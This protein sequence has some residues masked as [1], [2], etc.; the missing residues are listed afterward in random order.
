MLTIFFRKALDQKLL[1]KRMNSFLIYNAFF[2]IFLLTNLTYEKVLF[3]DLLTNDNELILLEATNSL[4]KKDSTNINRLK[5]FDDEVTVKSKIIV[6]ILYKN[7]SNENNRITEVSKKNTVVYFASNKQASCDKNVCKSNEL[8]ILRKPTQNNQK[9]YQCI[10]VNS[11]KN[12]QT[13]KLNLPKNINCSSDTISNV[14]ITLFEIFQRLTKEFSLKKDL[15]EPTTINKFCLKTISNSFTKLDLNKD[16][17]IDL[18]EWSELEL[19]NLDECA[20]QVFDRCDLNND[21]SLSLE[22]LCDCFDSSQHRCN[23]IRNAIHLNELKNYV[24]TIEN[25]FSKTKNMVKIKL[26]NKNYLPL[27]EMDGYFKSLQCDRDVTCWCVDKEGNPIVNTL[28]RID[29]EPINCYK[30]NFNLK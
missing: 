25:L 7:L 2:T 15:I 30:D 28:R 19:T 13:V 11:T 9:E 27:C 18:N 4:S 10:I 16:F 14:K 6:N 12:Q 29:Q 17:K 26:T 8:C 1:N 20:L 21:G 3:N 24:K 22:E 5:Q 23:Y